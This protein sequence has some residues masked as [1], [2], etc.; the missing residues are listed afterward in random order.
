MKNN[1][2]NK[3][4]FGKNKTKA[5]FGGQTELIVYHGDITTLVVDAVVNAANEKLLGGGGV[6]G[7]IH[8]AAGPALLKECQGLGGCQTGEAVITKGYK[9][10][11]KYVIHTVGPKYGSEDG[12]EDNLLANC[13]QNSLRVAFEHNL[14]SIAF[15][16]ISTGVY[17]YPK[18]EAA[19][20][21]FRSVWHWLSDHNFYYFEKIY[22]VSYSEEDYDLNVFFFRQF[23]FS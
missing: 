17:R 3:D 18:E 20:V 4:T 19:E 14:K 2:V 6:D 5:V 15:P 22:F 10:P 23:D 7:A 9:L 11:A 21:A 16:N 8:A 13:Y 1:K 12:N